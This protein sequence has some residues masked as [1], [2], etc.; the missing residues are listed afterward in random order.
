MEPQE[1]I[2]ERNE[3]FESIKSDFAKQAKL[4]TIGF[5]IFCLLLGFFFFCLIIGMT[6]DVSI[7]EQVFFVVMLPL[8]IILGVIYKN[9]NSKMANADS[10]Q[11]LLAVYD[12]HKKIDM[13]L[14]AY[15]VAIL[16]AILI[17]IRD[18]SSISILFVIMLIV[19][20]IYVPSLKQT[21][22]INQ[23]REL[24]QQS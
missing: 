22:K 7:K 12:K 17:T 2:N 5:C 20:T 15:G 6:H 10:A 1:L 3:L 11:D 19:A 24:M 21:N 13:C 9:R 16:L 18:S 23:L 8:C 14:I 4:R